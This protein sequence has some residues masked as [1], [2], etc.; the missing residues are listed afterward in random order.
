VAMER[1]RHL[2][3]ALLA[4]VSERSDLLVQPCTTTMIH[5]K[6]PIVIATPDGLAFRPGIDKPEAVVEVKAP[7]Q[8][9]AAH[10]ADPALVP[11]GL[12]YYYLPQVI[13]EMAVTELDQALVGALINGNLWL[14]DV[15][16]NQ[17]LFDGLL[18]RAKEFWRCVELKTPPPVQDSQG[19]KWIN[20]FYKVQTEPELLKLEG[21][22]ERELGEQ[23]KLYAKLNAEVKKQTEG[24]KTLKGQIQQVIGPR[25]GLLGRDWKVTWKQAKDSKQTDWRTIAQLFSVT[26]KMIA[27]HTT[28]KPGARRF[29]VGEENED[30][31]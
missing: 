16:F 31:E 9:T 1:G 25:A 4:W 23:V 13:W 20:E 21:P 26:E 12:P 3:P 24:L 15:K 30:G 6:H 14:Y 18:D 10:W 8:R 22:V 2:E 27:E 7:G 5:K 29:L 19:A 11:D 28:V 17:K